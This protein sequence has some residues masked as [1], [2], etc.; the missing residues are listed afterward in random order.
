MKDLTKETY[1]SGNTNTTKL[2]IK[3]LANELLNTTWTFDIYRNETPKMINLA[4]L[5]W[6]FEFNNRKASA[7]LCSKRNKKIYI[8]EWLLMQNLNKSLEFENTL[9]HEIAHAID[10]ETRNVSD[11]G[12]IWK[13][14][15][16]RVLCTADRC[17]TR[18]QI[19]VTE[20]TKYTLICDNC[21]RKTPSHKK[22][23][24]LSACGKC[25]RELNG[26]RYT[27]KYILRQ[28]QNY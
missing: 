13:A 4:F 18:E 27:E 21:D 7:G 25:C 15:A 22:K 24:R 19:S 5:G 17:Y 8:S 16:R 14:I 3:K 12:R 11:H 20:N 2:E 1:F 23:K 28:V 26:G 9:R 6:E 10:F